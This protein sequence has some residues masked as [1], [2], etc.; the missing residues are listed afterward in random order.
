MTVVLEF[1]SR[2]TDQLFETQMRR[3]ARKISARAQIFP[4]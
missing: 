3:V 4:H 2:L 1:L